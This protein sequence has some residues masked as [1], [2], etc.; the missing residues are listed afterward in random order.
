MIERVRHIANT[1]T[2]PLGPTE[3]PYYRGPRELIHA[4][5]LLLLRPVTLASPSTLSSGLQS[6]CWVAIGPKMN[7]QLIIP[8][9]DAYH[10][11]LFRS[12]WR[13]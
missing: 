6:F 3:P 4:P 11:F 8:M 9:I 5:C 7:R 12:Q 10:G 13:F 2:D 1:L